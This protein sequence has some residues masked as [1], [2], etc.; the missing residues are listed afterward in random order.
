LE[1]FRLVQSTV[2]PASMKRNP[3]KSQDDDECFVHFQELLTSD[4]RLYEFAWK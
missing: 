1:E 3:L 4:F 2:A